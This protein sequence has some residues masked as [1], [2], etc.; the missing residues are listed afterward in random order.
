M[1]DKLTISDSAEVLIAIKEVTEPYQL[2][3]QLKV[4]L[5]E[6]DSIERNHHGDI[7]RQKT[8]VIKYWLRYSPDASWATLA[9]AMKEMGGFA[10]LTKTLS[11][12][13]GT[14]KLQEEEEE[15]QLLL[16]PLVMFS[17]QTSDLQPVVELPILLAPRSQG[18]PWDT[19]TPYYS[20]FW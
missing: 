13:G 12:M 3:I 20:P 11:I 8:E 2:G 7:G 10:R 17:H 9:N 18:R 14:A 16:K 4:D 6:L 5:A 15:K 1:T 19:C